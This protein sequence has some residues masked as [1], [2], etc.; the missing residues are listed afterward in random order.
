VRKR[1]EK[2]ECATVCAAEE[3]GN[4]PDL[5]EEICAQ[6]PWGTEFENPLLMYKLIHYSGLLD[7]G[8]PVTRHELTDDEWQLV[9]NLRA[10]MRAATPEQKPTWDALSGNTRS[11]A[12]STGRNK[13]FR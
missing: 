11:Q 5:V 3:A 7:A 6:C 8:C 9:G 4:P 1:M 10:E 12:P 2:R 13:G